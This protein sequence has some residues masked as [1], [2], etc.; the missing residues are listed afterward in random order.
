MPSNNNNDK[1][2]RL[3]TLGEI[4]TYLHS[5]LI[6]GRDRLPIVSSELLQAVKYDLKLLSR[7]LYLNALATTVKDPRPPHITNH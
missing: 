1:R 7:F 3:P 2:K 6:W 5:E 4:A